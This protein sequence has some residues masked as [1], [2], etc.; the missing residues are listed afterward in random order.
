MKRNHSAD[1]VIAYY[2]I[3][4][5]ETNKNEETNKSRKHLTNYVL[6]KAR[7]IVLQNYKRALPSHHNNNK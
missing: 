1:K 6:S 7:R 3:E 2:R 4:G 5:S